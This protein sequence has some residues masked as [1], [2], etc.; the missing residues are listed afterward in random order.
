MS[1]LVRRSMP[2][3]TDLVTQRRQAGREVLGVGVHNLTH[4]D[5][6]AY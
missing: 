3:S 1:Y 2:D 4:E 5:F 6:V